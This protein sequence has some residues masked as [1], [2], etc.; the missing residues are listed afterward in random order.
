MCTTKDIGE[1]FLGK[2]DELVLAF[3]KIM[4]TVMAWQPND[5]GASI[6]S[7][8]FTN[9]K[10]WL[11]IK[12]MKKELDVKFYHSDKIESEL[13]KKHTDYGNKFAHHLR[14]STEGDITL[15]HFELMRIGYDY[16][17]S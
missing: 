13:I 7:I 3:D 14:V 2:P 1:L 8:V 9:L 4:T 10:A 12:P 17:L 6:H 16:A 11:I 5:V 15:E